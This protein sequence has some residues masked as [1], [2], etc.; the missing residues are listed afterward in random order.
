MLLKFIIARLS[1]SVTMP[2]NLIILIPNEGHE[3]PRLPKEQRLI[4]QPY[5]PENIVVHPSYNL[6]WFVGDVGHTRT[7]SLVDSASNNV[8][9]SGDID[10]NQLSKPLLLNKAGLTNYLFEKDVNL[11][12]PTCHGRDN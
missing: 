7:I 9:K 11:S 8:F 12:N 4:N 2:K 3:S 1:T 10:F 5:V 6:R